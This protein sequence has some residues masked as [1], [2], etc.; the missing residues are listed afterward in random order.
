MTATRM[1]LEVDVR[2]YKWLLLAVL[3]LVASINYADR[4]VLSAVFPLLSRDLGMSDLGLAAIGSFFL[5]AY[6][7]FSPIAG[8]VGDRFSRSML[9]TVSV[10]AWT[11]SGPYPSR[12]H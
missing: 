12:Q 8:Y 11:Q 5:W 3:F 4:G 2:H 6:A 9:V 7:L 1:R 10:A